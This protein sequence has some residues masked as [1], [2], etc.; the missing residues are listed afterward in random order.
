MVKS[1]FS[2][3]FGK[4]E[5]IRADPVEVKANNED[6][7]FDAVDEALLSLGYLKPSSGKT[8]IR[9]LPSCVTEHPK[10][11]ATAF[12]KSG[13]QLSA[14]EIR[15]LGIRAN[16]YMSLQARDELSEKGLRHPLIAHQITLIRAHFTLSRHR[17]LAQFARAGIEFVEMSGSFPT[18]CKVC[19][20]TQGKKVTTSQ[21]SPFPPLGCEKE[22]CAMMFEGRFD[23]FSGV[24]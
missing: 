8:I 23:F 24:S 7:V 4:R 16:A 1:F 13:N 21:A 11:V 22:G 14:E 3:I 19:A 18:E 15:N 12:R 20:E 9:L 5:E 17:A 2:G 10:A 6:F